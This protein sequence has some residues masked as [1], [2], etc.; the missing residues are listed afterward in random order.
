VHVAV[1]TRNIFILARITAAN[2]FDA[3]LPSKEVL[4]DPFLWRGS[5]VLIL[6]A[7]LGLRGW[8][9]RRQAARKSCRLP[10][11]RELEQLR[12]A[13]FR[14]PI[15]IDCR[16]ASALALL[17]RARRGLIRHMDIRSAARDMRPLFL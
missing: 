12:A 10:E 14:L 16:D 1:A 4:D 3:R 11:G 9:W 5:I 15:V 2:F 7:L 8:R 17:P 6:G 13:A